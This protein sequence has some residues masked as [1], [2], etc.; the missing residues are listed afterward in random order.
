MF[1][2][3]LLIGAMLASTAAN[4]ATITAPAGVVVKHTVEGLLTAA[5]LGASTTNYEVVLG[6]EYAINDTITFTYSVAFSTETPVNPPS[7]II[8]DAEAASDTITFGLLS[9]TTTSLTYRALSTT[10]Q[11]GDGVVTTGLKCLSP[12]VELNDTALAAAGSATMSFSAA[13]SAGTAIDAV[14][15]AGNAKSVAT[16]VAQFA[17]TTS[18]SFDAVVDVNEDRKKFTGAAVTDSLVFTPAVTAAV[19]GETLTRNANAAHTTAAAG[20]V[21]VSATI[22]AITATVT[23]DFSFLDTDADTAGTQLGTNTVTA[24]DSTVTFGANSSSIIATDDNTGV[25]AT[26]VAITKNVAATAFPVQAYTGNVVIDYDLVATTKSVTMP[27]TGGSWTLN[28]ATLTAFSVPFSPTVE[29]FLWISNSGASAGEIT[30]SVL[31]D[32]TRYPTTGSY[33]LGSAAAKANTRI[34]QL[35]DDALAADG[36]S[37]TSGRA[38]VTVTVNAAASG[39]TMNAGYKVGDDRMHLETTDSLDGDDT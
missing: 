25:Q 24:T 1:K 28:G 32:G 2:K 27:I 34:T 8:C 22:R 3:S 19:D 7:Q 26:T 16:A 15:A 9:T 36:A 18:T 17:T 38:D 5:T 4:S 12:I 39:I 11:G 14:A 37:I 29:R 31:H 13:T 35:L 6:A 33:A 30:A 20:A 23:G 21:A 10:D